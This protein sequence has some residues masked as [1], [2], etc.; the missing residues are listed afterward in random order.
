MCMTEMRRSQHT[1]YRHACTACRSRKV[2]RPATCGVQGRVR[3]PRAVYT[4]H[5]RFGAWGVDVCDTRVL[6]RHDGF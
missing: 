3:V 5:G 6:P 1:R 2:R 4:V